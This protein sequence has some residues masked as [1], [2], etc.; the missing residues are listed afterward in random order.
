MVMTAEILGNQISVELHKG[1]PEG[2]INEFEMLLKMFRN[3]MG[4]IFEKNLR[5][6]L[7]Y[8]MKLLRMKLLIE[9]GIGL[10]ALVLNRRGFFEWHACA[11]I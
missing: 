6:S 1:I 9:R 5:K 4:E 7:P 2:N 10:V 3:I 8:K 11:I